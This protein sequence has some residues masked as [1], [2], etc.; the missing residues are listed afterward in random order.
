MTAPKLPFSPRRLSLCS[1][2][3][4]LLLAG[5]AGHSGALASGQSFALASDLS[6]RL[7]SSRPASHQLQLQITIL[8]TG[9][10]AI[11]TLV[12]AVLVT[13]DGG[14]ENGASLDLQSDRANITMTLDGADQVGY[15]TV[16][17][18]RDGHSARWSVAAQALAG[19]QG[20][21]GCRLVGV[22]QPRPVQP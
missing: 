21:S 14:H 19:C 4:L 11:E 3:A 12:P 6:V 16:S 1:A 2:L 10:T 22:P 7:V 13:P 8:A 15:V 18:S 20:D 17:D 5:C 9:R